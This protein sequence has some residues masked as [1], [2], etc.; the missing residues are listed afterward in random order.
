MNYEDQEMKELREKWEEMS[1]EDKVDKFLWKMV[2][3]HHTKHI[4][5][6]PTQSIWDL[7]K[8]IENVSSSS[9]NLTNSIKNATWV[10]GIAAVLGLIV[11]ILSLFLSYQKNNISVSQKVFEEC[12]DYYAQQNSSKGIDKTAV[13]TC[14][15]KAEQWANL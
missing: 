13:K 8:V 10:A 9:E 14:K 3:Y 1:Q 5:S 12:F 15:V 2:W 11:G 7:S 4:P 6:S